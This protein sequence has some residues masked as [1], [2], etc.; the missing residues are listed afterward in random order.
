[1]RFVLLFFLVL[2]AAAGLAWALHIDRGYV[3]LSYGGWSAELS[4]ASFIVLLAIGLF[5]LSALLRFI[6]WLWRMPQRLQDMYRR[7]R[8]LRARRGLI[9]GMIDLAEGRLREG[10]KKFIRH[11]AHS[12]APLLN[13]LAAARAAQLQRAYERRDSHLRQAT[14]STPQ[15]AI[16]VLLTQAELQIAHQQYEHA[17]AA[18][19]RLQELKPGHA[20]GLKLLARLNSSMGDWRGLEELLPRLRKANALRPDEVEQYEI[21]VLHER[22]KLLSQP[23][24]EEALKTLWHNVP[25]RL[26]HQAD[27]VRAYARALR[28]ADA[29]DTAESLLRDALRREWD[30]AL[31]LAYGTVVSSNPARQMARA[32]AWL[33]EHSESAALLLTAGRLCM[34]NQVWGKARAYLESSLALAPQVE[35]YDELGKLYQAMGQPELAMEAYRNGLELSLRGKVS[36]APRKKRNPRDTSSMTIPGFVRSA[37]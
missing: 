17:Q 34:A 14:E 8:Q 36:K 4:L 9:R 25:R 5:V 37:N 11:A 33:K 12:E 26:R 3:L 10:E 20:Y 21:Q 35:T 16:A 31:V 28:A 6:I 13:H 1:M 15:A 27:L 24:E 2:C 32:E 30:D 19:K 29:R 23:G 18:L 22:F 7:R